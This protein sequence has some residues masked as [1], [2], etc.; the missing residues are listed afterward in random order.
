MG[1]HIGVLRSL[2]IYYAIPGR[3]RRMRRF[4]RQFV[5]PGDLCFDIG[6]HLGNHVRAWLDLGARVV[7]VEP[8]PHLLTWLGRFYGR[9]PQVTL[10]PQAVGAVEGTAAL[11][12]SQRTPTVS[13]LSAAWMKLVGQDRSFADVVWE[14]AV[15]VPVTTLDRLVEQYGRP[16]FT[17]IDVEGY[18]LEVLQ[19]LSQPLPA[20]SFEYIVAVREMALSCLERLKQLGAYEFNYSTGESYKLVLP[21]WAST[22]EMA[23]VL[24]Q[25]AEGRGDIYGR[26]VRKTRG[27]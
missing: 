15:P 17:K 18:E 21:A 11:Y 20:L 6:A 25:L 13:T 8:Q 7:A 19:G 4:Y 23:G 9:H 26:L 2:L 24:S 16:A 10:L 3:R 12:I 27:I 14:T 1:Q 5:Q 22:A